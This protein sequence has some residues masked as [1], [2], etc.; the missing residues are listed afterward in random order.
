MGKFWNYTFMWC[1]LTGTFIN[2][3]IQFT[4]SLFSHRDDVTEGCMCKQLNVIDVGGHLIV[5][6]VALVT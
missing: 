5:N 2:M 3:I 1:V 6:N 4:N